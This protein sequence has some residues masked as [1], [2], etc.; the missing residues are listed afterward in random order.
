M[1]CYGRSPRDAGSSPTTYL[2]VFVFSHFSF[3]LVKC[4]TPE[5]FLG[6]LI[7][8]LIGLVN[9]KQAIFFVID[10]QISI[11]NCKYS[12]TS[13]YFLQ[14]SLCKLLCS[15]DSITSSKKKYNKKYILP[16]I[17]HIR[18]TLSVELRNTTP[19]IF[20]FPEQKSNIIY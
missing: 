1:D 12:K 3:Y 16:Y 15:A 7:V 2:F 19:H 17:S 10:Q 11:C 18:E 14:L 5:Y 20:L 4:G 8:G 9:F 13:L 6:F